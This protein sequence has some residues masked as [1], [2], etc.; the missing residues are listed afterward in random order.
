MQESQEDSLA[1]RRF[2]YAVKCISEFIEAHDAKPVGLDDL[3][4]KSLIG[5]LEFIAASEDADFKTASAY[6]Y[7]QHEYSWKIETIKDALFDINNA[8]KRSPKTNEAWE[9]FRK[10]TVRTAPTE[11]TGDQP[12]MPARFVE[13]CEQLF[14]LWKRDE[15]CPDDWPPK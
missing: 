10:I 6:P 15:L 3:D 11:W 9:A 2:N 13:W 5:L 8:K 1:T 12:E 7:S 14:P 4:T